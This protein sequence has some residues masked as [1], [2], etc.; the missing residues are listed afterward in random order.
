VRQDK[1]QKQKK[2]ADQIDS[3]RRSQWKFNL[4]KTAV[5]HASVPLMVKASGSHSYDLIASGVLINILDHV[6]L[7]TAGHALEAL[8]DSSIFVPIRDGRI[9]EIGGAGRISPK[10]DAGILHL[11]VQYLDQFRDVALPAGLVYATELLI[12]DPLILYGY[13]ARNFKRKGKVASCVPGFYLMT[14]RTESVYKRLRYDPRDHILLD[15]PKKLFG[16]HALVRSHSLAAMSG[17]GVW[18]IP[19]P[20]SPHLKHSTLFPS[21]LPKLV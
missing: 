18:L 6:F 17:C 9:L 19:Q 21:P 14:T 7:F 11:E 15:W 16:P 1:K 3:V 13:P 10:L 5:A 2:V 20:G 8:K 12:P 4:A